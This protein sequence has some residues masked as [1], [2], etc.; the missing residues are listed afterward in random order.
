M[1]ARGGTILAAAGGS[2]SWRTVVNSGLLSR[3][4]A[5]R[6]CGVGTLTVVAATTA[7]QPLAGSTCTGGTA[8]VFVLDHRWRLV[9][10]KLSSTGVGTRTSVLRLVTT[11]AVWSVLAAIAEPGGPRIVA[12][13]SVDGGAEWSV[14]APLDAGSSARLESTA[15]NGE[16]FVVQAGRSGGSSAAWSIAGP[17]AGW[18]RVPDLPA[19]TEVVIGGPDDRID[20]LV[21]DQSALTDWTLH[22]P[23]G[24]WEKRQVITVPIQYGSSG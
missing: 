22:A 15:D 18:Q 19:G 20:A 5:G 16:A 3:T 14:S 9:G 17:H 7:D 21:V 13:W 8:G 11:G 10:P 23:T 2:T 4:A 1:R 6:T 12:A 24:V